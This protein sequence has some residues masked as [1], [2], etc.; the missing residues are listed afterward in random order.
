LL[1]VVGEML[2][3]RPFL[4]PWVAF[5]PCSNPSPVRIGSLP[6]LSQHLSSHAFHVAEWSVEDRDTKIGFWPFSAWERF[7]V[8]GGRTTQL[9]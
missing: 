2:A 9:G 7:A 6:C 8:E 4:G 3:L 1:S 5:R